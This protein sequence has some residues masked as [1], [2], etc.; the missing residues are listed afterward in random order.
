M[1]RAVFFAI[2]CPLDHIQQNMGTILTDS[3]LF[4][5]VSTE[6]LFWGLTQ[7]RFVLYWRQIAD[8]R[9]LSFKI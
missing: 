5:T 2:P 1:C 6:S 3:A 8:Y 7:Y 9:V 4:R